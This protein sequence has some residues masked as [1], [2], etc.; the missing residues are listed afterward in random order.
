MKQTHGVRS[1]LSLTLC[2]ALCSPGLTLAQ[3]P[4]ATP[5]AAPK[6]KLTIVEGASTSKR[7]KKG[8]VSSQAVIKITD[9]N[10]V[11]VPAIAVTFTLPVVAS[12]ANG[13]ATAIVTTNAAGIASSGSFSAAAGSTFSVGAVASVPGG[14][15]TAAVPITTAAAAVA[16][17]GAISGGLLAGIIAGA[18]AAA[19]AGIYVATKKS[20]PGT[21]TGTIGG[22]GTPTFGHP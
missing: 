2:L 8:R 22:A 15:V 11:P 14:T 7:V 5:A 12:F 18:G 21:P 6:Y 17:G 10:D 9:E 13:G 1:T 3:Q 20:G 16:T 4:A 19:A